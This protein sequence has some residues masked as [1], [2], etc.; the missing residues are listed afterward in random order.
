M[1]RLHVAIALGGG[2]GVCLA[3]LVAVDALT[4]HRQ[5]PQALVA[6]VL[7]SKSSISPADAMLLLALAVIVV[8]SIGLGAR[9]AWAEFC[10]YRRANRAVRGSRSVGVDGSVVGVLSDRRPRAFCHGFLRPGIYVSSGTLAAL[11]AP[12]LGALVAHERHHAFLRDP[13]RL[14]VARVLGSALFFLPVL[15]RLLDRYAEEAELAADEAAVRHG[16]GVAALAAALLTFDER[17]SGV[18]PSRVDRLLGLR[19]E[20]R[21]PRT[22]VLTTAAI[23]GAVVGLALMAATVNGH[24]LSCIAAP[25]LLV[26][27]GLAAVAFATPLGLLSPVAR[28][29]RRDL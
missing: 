12:E 8:S 19:I 13:L 17:G 23:I 1:Y 7:A 10:A 29:H 20:R 18:H 24:E 2:F 21:V 27:A 26:T 3:L 4:T 15:P 6:T 14:A 22:W 9:A 16:D 5:S 11:S 25:A 28:R